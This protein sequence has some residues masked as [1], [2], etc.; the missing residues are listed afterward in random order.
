MAGSGP[1]E[2]VIVRPPQEGFGF[3]LSRLGTVHF[4]RVV[5]P[6]SAASKA[7]ALVPDRILKINGQDVTEVSHGD[8]VALIK[9][10]GRELRMTVQLISQ[11]E[12]D[13]LQSE[14][15]SGSRHGSFSGLAPAQQMAAALQPPPQ[16][17]RH[18][19]PQ[20]PQQRGPP[21]PQQVAQPGPAHLARS[22]PTNLKTVS[23]VRAEGSF[24]FNLSRLE[25]RHVVRVVQPRGAAEAAGLYPGDEVIVVNNAVVMNAEHSDVVSLIKQAGEQIVLEVV[26]SSAG[27]ITQ[28]AINA[29]PILKSRAQPAVVK[30]EDRIAEARRRAEAEWQA[31][32]DALVRQ[33]EEERQRTRRELFE[34]ERT[35]L[36][37][38]LERA[39]AA[40]KAAA[41]HRGS[42][43]NTAQSFAKEEE[44]KEMARVLRDIEQSSREELARRHQEPLSDDE[45]DAQLTTLRRQL[46]AAV[47]EDEIMNVHTSEWTRFGLDCKERRA[48]EERDA[49]SLHEKLKVQRDQDLKLL[50]EKQQRMAERLEQARR[51]REEEIEAARRQRE[52][53]R[54]QQ[55][56]VYE[57]RFKQAQEAA[58]RRAE[59]REREL[60]QEARRLR[61]EEESAQVREQ[62]E[63]EMAARSARLQE[64]QQEE[65]Q[66]KQQEGT[67]FGVPL[68]RATAPQSRQGDAM[69]PMVQLMQ[70]AKSQGPRVPLVPGM[71]D[72]K[73]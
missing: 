60:E 20:A 57:K 17:I 25:G 64:R 68:K 13:R 73:M 49:S 46:E 5:E 43:M 23:I 10:A 35:R 3:N 18:S 48:V 62:Q 53:E 37:N 72:T 15:N 39:Q 34:G 29:D 38:E 31:K 47:L 9:Q 12:L 61:L 55:Q 30:S 63:R 56:E 36:Q 6:G 27:P 58:R 1:R 28:A 44:Y 33:Q 69:H 67:F 7:G 19:Q 2:L 32:R 24:G 50:Q 21:Q 16:Q 22:V 71:K 42:A 41:A 65:A 14:G 70:G 51:Q 4:L 8:L 11:D 45:Y 66:G 59:E 26:P 54:R 52:E 40:A